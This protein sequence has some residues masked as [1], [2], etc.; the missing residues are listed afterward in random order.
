MTESF[1]EAQQTDKVI[2]SIH[3]KLVI[4]RK[5][6]D[7]QSYQALERAFEAVKNRYYAERWGKTR[8]AKLETLKLKQEILA[9]AQKLSRYDEKEVSF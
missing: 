6:M 9:T 7:L 1:T 5:T 3:N 2:A 8:E 4:A